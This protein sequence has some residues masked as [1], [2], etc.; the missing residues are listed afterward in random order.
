MDSFI[1]DFNNKIKS[2][3]YR[4][5]DSIRFNNVR[6]LPNDCFA[7]KYYKNYNSKVQVKNRIYIDYETLYEIVINSDYNECPKN[8]MLF[9]LRLYDWFNWPN[10]GKISIENYEHF[11]DKYKDLVQ[12][13][14]NVLLLYGGCN[15][16]KENSNKTDVFID[17]LTKK[18]KKYNSNIFNITS[19]NT[20]QDFKYIITSE[21]YIPSLGGF[22]NLAG[23]LNKNR[24]YWELSEK[25]INNYK[26]IHDKNDII[27]FKDY[28]INN[29]VKTKAIVV[30]TRGYSNIIQYNQLI[31]RNKI[32]EDTIISNTDY[33]IFHE[34]N[35][36]VEHQTYISNKTPG[37][38]LQFVNVEKDFKKINTD[39]DPRTRHFGLGY[40]NMCNFWFSNFW[41]YIEKYEKIVRIDEDIKLY[42]DINFIFDKLNT[43][44]ACYGTWHSDCDFVTK[45]LNN[46]TLQFF[47][48]KYNED[49]VARN[50]SGPYTNVI[51]WNI[52]E[53]RKNN[54]IF[55]YIDEVKK[56]NMIYY[57]RWG[58]LPLWGE[59]LFYFYDI[60]DY[61]ECK[62]IKYYHGSN[63]GT[64]NME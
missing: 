44:I 24:V 62:E 59:I 17:T 21:H 7:H 34:G 55:E 57:N 38:D 31:E 45:N 26:S 6:H 51:G 49:K 58:D 41:K 32:L 33:I 40:R 37:L 35:I 29:M 4:L 39:I 52:K 1:S 47:K 61:C 60:E 12:N 64:Y 18:L 63:K 56:T 48:E 20:D 53:L 43:K 50:P 54:K 2:L 15:K 9:H 25:F 8:S 28:Y 11:I 46:T 16:N 30:L 36:P 22:S 19:E 10:T 5:S 14:D 27:N 42:S 23:A 13:V 3:N